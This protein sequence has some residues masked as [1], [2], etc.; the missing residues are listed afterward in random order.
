[1]PQSSHSRASG[2]VLASLWTLDKKLLILVFSKCHLLR[3][4]TACCKSKAQGQE[5]EHLEEEKNEMSKHEV[6]SF[7]THDSTAMLTKKVF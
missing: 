1:M 2:E 3:S 7:N 4:K 6:G 5:L